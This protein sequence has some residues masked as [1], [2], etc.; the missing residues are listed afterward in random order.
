MASQIGLTINAIGRDQAT[1]G[2]AVSFTINAGSTTR[3][4][5]VRTNHATI[6]TTSLPNATFISGTTDFVN[7]QLRI[8]PVASNP[9]QTTTHHEPFPGYRDSTMLSYWGSVVIEQSTTGFAME[10][11]GDMNDS[12]GGQ[13]VRGE[14]NGSGRLN[15][16]IAGPAAP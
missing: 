7:G 14:L 9:E 2:S 13:V 6:N 16:P 4:F 5:I 8:S 15:K 3:V 1:F 10:F 12:Q 11:I